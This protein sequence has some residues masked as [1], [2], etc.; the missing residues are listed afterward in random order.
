MVKRSTSSEMSELKCVFEHI[1]M[2]VLSIVLG[3]EQRAS[4]VDTTLKVK[5][6][7]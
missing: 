4:L 7:I 2:H 5:R 6:E 1:Y 3:L